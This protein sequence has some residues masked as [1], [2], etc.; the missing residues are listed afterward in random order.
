[1]FNQTGFQDIGKYIN[2]CKTQDNTLGFQAF[3]RLVCSIMIYFHGVI[4]IF[5]NVML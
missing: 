3:S 4:A 1:M 5:K 2:T